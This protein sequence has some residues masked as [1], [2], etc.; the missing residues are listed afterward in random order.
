[1][2]AD[3]WE[4]DMTADAGKRWTHLAQDDTSDEEDEDENEEEEEEDEDDLE[5]VETSEEEDALETG[6]EVDDVA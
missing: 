1:V 4:T 2:E 3:D 5:V 6:S